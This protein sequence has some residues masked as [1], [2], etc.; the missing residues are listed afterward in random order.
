MLLPTTYSG[1]LL[2][3][4]LAGVLW[5]LWAN[6][7]RLDRK[8][9]F[10]LYATD[11][12]IGGLLGALLL[13][14]TVGNSGAGNTLTFEDNLTIAGKRS[15]AIAA[16]AGILYCVGNLLTMAGLTLAGMS[17]ALPVA[18][19]VAL[20]VGTLFHGGGKAGMTW[21]GA[22][23]GLAA[24]AVSALAQ[25]AAAAA[26]PAKKGLSPG[27]K[28][29][30]LSAAGGVF[31]GASLP[32]AEWSRASEIGLGAYGAAVFLCLGLLAVT[33]MAN[34]YFLNLPVQGAPLSFLAY[35]KAPK[36]QHLAGLAGGILWAGGTTAF[37]AAAGATYEGGPKF[38]ALQAAALG[39]AVLGGLCGLLFWGEQA[40]SGKAKGLILLS[41]LVLGAGLGLAFAGA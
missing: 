32:V 18:A 14:Y 5:G 27:V 2:T 39:G 24:V 25:R 15:M 11:F 19:G 34:I 38:L 41:L 3:I 26:A 13:A 12:A 31:L 16:G 17:T 9:R 29:L 6:L 40:E 10:E 33:P 23:V 1:V 36:G 4:A 35:F 22:G 37:F 8:W 21:A 30:I 20:A 7:L 28:G